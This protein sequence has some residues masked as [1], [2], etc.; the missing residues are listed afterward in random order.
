MFIRKPYCSEGSF[1]FYPKLAYYS[2][3]FYPIFFIVLFLWILSGTQVSQIGII[4]FSWHTQAIELT[5]LHDNGWAGGCGNYE[6][7]PNNF[8][9]VFSFFRRFGQLLHTLEEMQADNHQIA[10]SSFA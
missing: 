9:L 10:C 4:R 2:F 8:L 6:P 5:G 7:V 1:G 3:G